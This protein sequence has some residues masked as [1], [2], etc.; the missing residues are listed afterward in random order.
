MSQV[1]IV[2][3][4][5]N[6]RNKNYS[7]HLDLVVDKN[8]AV[9]KSSLIKQSKIWS[10]FKFRL[11]TVRNSVKFLQKCQYLI[12]LRFNNLKLWRNSIGYHSFLQ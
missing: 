6:F 5:K 1:P 3:N 8:R 7:L 11:F 4:S 2:N 10:A 9:K 12:G